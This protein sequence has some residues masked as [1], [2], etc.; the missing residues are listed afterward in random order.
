MAELSAI[1]WTDATVNFW[2][3]CAKVG[4]GCQN[5]YAEK[6]AERAGRVGLW[7]GNRERTK[8][9]NEPIKWQRMAKKFF[10]EH[11]RMRRVF[12]NSLSDFLDI[13]IPIGW[14][15]DA[16]AIIRQCQDLEWYVVSKRIPNF[17]KM[18]PPD[19]CE[20]LYGHIVLIATVVTQ[21]E[22][23]RDSERLT[24]I[25]QKFPW[26]RVGLSMEPLLEHVEMGDR[27]PCDWVIVG[28]ESGVGKAR[29]M[30][31][32]WVLAI[33]QWCWTYDV[34][35]HMKQVG[36]NHEGWAMKLSG[37]GD[38]PPEWPAGL[39]ERS[40]PRPICTSKT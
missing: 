30:R 13:D 19:F 4:P 26:L 27:W 32:E 21:A 15:D 9:W 3:G 22:Y 11:G 7:S 31:P 17:L 8:T 6:W 20:L 10:T 28:G 14:R 33:Q 34:P 5:C 36:H 25:K 23:D 38:Y 29:P 1:S 37:K 24:A 35:F 2:V 39:R 18:L 16:W 12:C 40:F